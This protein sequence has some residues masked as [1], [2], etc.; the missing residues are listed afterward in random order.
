MNQAKKILLIRFSSIGDIVLTSPVVRCIK[1][2][3]PDCS[4]HVLTKKQNAELFAHNPYVDKVHVL[5]KDLTEVIR[6]LKEEQFDFV[7]DLH[8]NLRSMRVRTALGVRS[9]GFPKLNLKKYVLVRFKWNLMPAVHVVDRYFEAVK[10]LGVVNDGAGLDFFAGDAGIPE[11]APSWINT[12]FLA[13]VIGGQHNTK[14]LPANKVAEVVQ[15]VDMPVVLLGGP[16][17]RERG[18][19]IEEL[20]GKAT[21]WNACGRLSL[22]Q[23]ARVVGRASVVLSNDT[24]LMHIAA[25]YRKPLVSVW[26]N[27]VPAL[28]MYPYMPGDESKSVIVENTKVSCR[29]CSKIGFDSC[30]KKHFECMNSLDAGHIVASA[31]RLKQMSGA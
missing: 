21:V 1:K 17:D 8:C 19:L 7:A 29:P 15:K 3:L 24:G 28:G 31:K 10:P 9:E 11:D 26:G 4:L 25:A 13:V 20:S 27:T 18:S 16:A 5:D 6:Q 14:I 23:S 30:P 22:M 12:D 2:Q